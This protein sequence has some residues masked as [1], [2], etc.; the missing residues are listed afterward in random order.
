[1]VGL[2]AAGAA[3]VCVSGTWHL[4]LNLPGPLTTPAT[5]VVEKGENVQ[6]IAN[7]LHKA[8]VVRSPLL[9][10]AAVKATFTTRQLQAGEYVFE[11]GDSLSR[12]VYKMVGGHVVQR[13]LTIPEGI[14][15]AEVI[16]MLKNNDALTGPVPPMP[17]GSLLPETYAFTK[18]E[19]RVDVA[20]RMAAAMNTVLMQAWEGRAADLPVT[21]P[22]ELLT[23]ASIVEKETG[24]DDERARVAGV[25]VNRLKKGMRLQADPTVIYGA[26]NYHGNLTRKHLRDP[27]PYNT[28]VHQGLPK[29]PIANPGAASLFAAANPE[30]HSYYFFVA[31]GSGGHLFASTHAEHKK[32]VSAYLKWYKQTYN[33]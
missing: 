25:Y 7:K 30:R 28:Y 1:M 26:S 17:E 16:D 27:H 6:H 19:R 18:G 3:L 8:G 11:P 13:S 31:D 2:I 5:V 15:T 32:N 14:T 21:S 9:L 12:V 23:L 24:R 33:R 4:L 22:E 20:R 29:G 10:K